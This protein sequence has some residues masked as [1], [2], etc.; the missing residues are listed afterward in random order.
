MGKTGAAVS[1]CRLLSYAGLSVVLTSFDGAQTPRH[2]DLVVPDSI[3]L[4]TI[5]MNVK[6]PSRILVE[7]KPH[8]ALLVTR[9]RLSLLYS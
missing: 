3:L 7:K 1:I 8:R 4:E 2:I 5:T 9:S 6:I